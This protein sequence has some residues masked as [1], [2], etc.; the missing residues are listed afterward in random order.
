MQ[1]EGL[2]LTASFWQDFANR[3]WEK[4]PTVLRGVLRSPIATPAEALQ[5]FV[6]AAD[7]AKS[8][9]MVWL[10]GEASTLKRELFPTSADQSLDDFVR[11]AAGKKEICIAQYNLHVQTAELWLR[12]REFLRG[13]YAVIGI[14]PVVD[15]DAF[16]GR[17]RSTPQGPHT[18]SASNFS[19][20][21]ESTK[22]M[23]LW[24]PEAFPEE[25]IKIVAAH[26]KRKDIEWRDFERSVSKATVIEAEPGDLGIPVSAAI[27]R[28]TDNPQEHIIMGFGAHYNARIAVLRAVTELNQTLIGL[29]PD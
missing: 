20:P 27:S 6:R 28:R 22:K 13:L 7:A 16:Y 18:D 24:P 4:T 23:M 26:N 19:F 10:D 25:A 8:Y 17:Y 11:R 2:D 29:R 12:A 21:I 9:R 3:H 15:I 1:F 5:S 14:P